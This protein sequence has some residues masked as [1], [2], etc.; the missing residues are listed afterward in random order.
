M[1]RASVTLVIAV[2]LPFLVLAALAAVGLVPG[3]WE[4]LIAFALGV[5]AAAVY[6]RR[7]EPAPS[8]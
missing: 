3:G 1:R 2:V 5:T 7:S 6:W 4:M 8:E